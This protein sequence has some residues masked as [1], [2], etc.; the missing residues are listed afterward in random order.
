[1]ASSH[2]RDSRLSNC[3][4]ISPYIKDE[5]RIVDLLQLGGIGRIVQTYDGDLGR[6]DTSHFVMSQLHRLTGSSDWADTV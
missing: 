6:G 3:V 2:D 5:R 1:M 4:H